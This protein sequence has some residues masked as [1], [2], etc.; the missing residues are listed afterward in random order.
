MCFYFSLFVVMLDIQQYI[1]NP[2]IAVSE[3][4]STTT[5]FELD[6]IPRG[7]GHTLGNALRRIILG[8]DLGGALTGAKIDGVSHEYHIM[9]GVKESVIDILLNLKNLRFS[10]GDVEDEVIWFDSVVSGVGEHTASALSLPAGVTLLNPDAPL[11]AVSDPSFSAKIALRVEKGYGYYSLQYLQSRDAENEAQDVDML[12]IDNDFKL[13]DYVTYNVE[14]VIDD[15]K[16]GVK[17]KLILEVKS[18]FDGVSPQEILAFAGEVLASYAKLFIFDN[19]YIDKSKLVEYDDLQSD[20]PA[21]AY[22][23]DYQ[24][25]TMPIDAL[26]L[27]ERTRNALI[28]NNILYVEDLEKKKKGE[29]LLMKGVGRKAID[30][31]ISALE[32]IDKSLVA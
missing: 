24:V 25:K 20:A 19:V 17:D 7:F 16:G 3:K 6:N 5:L 32:S 8:Y 23:D 2:H 15:F 4:D 21:S 29:L 18:R 14:Q 10:M 30:E 9:D 11:F 13:V 28:K 1:G 12:Y 27:S 31:I 22:G 26:P